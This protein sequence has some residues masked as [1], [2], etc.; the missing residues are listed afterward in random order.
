MYVVR[1]NKTGDKWEA[2]KQEHTIHKILASISKNVKG[3]TNIV[4]KI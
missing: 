4:L 3:L 1:S 2:S